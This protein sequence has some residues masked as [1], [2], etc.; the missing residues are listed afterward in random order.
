MTKNISLSGFELVA[1]RIQV[2]NKKFTAFDLFNSRN[3]ISMGGNVF[4]CA[5]GTSTRRPL[6]FQ[7]TM[8]NMQQLFADEYIRKVKNGDSC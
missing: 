6:Q 5:Y 1:Y 8:R 3:F 4:T 2:S 7:N